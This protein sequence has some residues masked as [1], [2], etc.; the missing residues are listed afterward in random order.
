MSRPVWCPHIDCIWKTGGGNPEDSG[1]ACGGELPEAVYHGET[2]NT[3]RLCIKPSDDAPFDLQLNKTDI[4]Y[5]KRILGA[6]TP[7]DKEPK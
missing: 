1:V 7:A 5:L 3:H 4:W 6:L 2:S